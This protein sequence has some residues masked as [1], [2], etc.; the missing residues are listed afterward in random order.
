LAFDYRIVARRK[1]YEEIRLADKTQ[2]FAANRLRQMARPQNA[3]SISAADAR[4][5]VLLMA[6]HPIAQVRK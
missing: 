6:A 3:A 5:T 1:G 4:T 2:V